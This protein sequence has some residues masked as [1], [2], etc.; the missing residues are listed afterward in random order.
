MTEV[1]ARR[2]LTG[3]LGWAGAISFAVGLGAALA[4]VPWGNKVATLGLGLITAAS[5]ADP[6]RRLPWQLRVGLAVL[7]ALSAMT[8]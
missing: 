5:E 7:T 8:I 3:T 4:S 6:D 2:L 1:Q